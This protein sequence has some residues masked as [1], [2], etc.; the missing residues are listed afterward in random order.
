MWTQSSQALFEQLRKRNCKGSGLAL[1]GS[2]ESNSN[3]DTKII[4]VSHALSEHVYMR[5]YKGMGQFCRDHV[6]QVFKYPE[7]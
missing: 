1:N 3:F 2:F 6:N 5:N 4:Q 7:C